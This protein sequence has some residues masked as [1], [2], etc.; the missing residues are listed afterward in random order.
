MNTKILITGLMVL[1]VAIGLGIGISINQ[2]TREAE[3][4]GF[5]SAGELIASRFLLAVANL[6]LAVGSTLAIFIIFGLPTIGLGL[7]VWWIKKQKR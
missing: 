6:S 2:A 3:D 1:A 4:F 5:N 7:T